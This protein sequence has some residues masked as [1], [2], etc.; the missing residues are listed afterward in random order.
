ME[1]DYEISDSLFIRSFSGEK[2]VEK[3]EAN[4]RMSYQG[5]SDIVKDKEHHIIK[6]Y[7]FEL[8]SCDLECNIKLSVIHIMY[9]SSCNIDFKK[10]TFYLGR[11]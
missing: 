2:A 10:L 6:R 4:L 11:R 7:K 8:H 1:N 3:E 5:S 9:M